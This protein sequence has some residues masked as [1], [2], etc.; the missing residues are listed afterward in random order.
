MSSSSK[1]NQDENLSYQ[2]PGVQRQ[3]I[4]E[5]CFS[6]KVLSDP[7]SLSQEACFSTPWCREE[8][9]RF[10]VSRLLIVVAKD[11]RSRHKQFLQRLSFSVMNQS[12]TLPTP[13]YFFIKFHLFQPP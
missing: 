7:V 8:P 12:Q 9:D 5:W 4:V 13:Q 6:D 10:I 2:I 1:E 3:K 11:W